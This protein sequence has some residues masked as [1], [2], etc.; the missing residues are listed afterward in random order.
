MGYC[1]RHL[2]ILLIIIG[3]ISANLIFGQNE[4]LDY[5]AVKKAI[6]G[7]WTQ[8]DTVSG[9]KVKYR[10]TTKKIT[11]YLY[12]QDNTILKRTFNYTLNRE[13]NDELNKS[14]IIMILPAKAG[15]LA[16]HDC[17]FCAEKTLDHLAFFNWMDI[18]IK[19]NKLSSFTE[20][21]NKD[22][23]TLIKE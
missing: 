15:K 2:K 10:I 19:N 4:E 11:C 3:I 16:S 5:E 22:R 9:I 12:C 23:F 20:F 21:N 6:I 8:V 18:V 17:N 14:I 1:I 13:F 7:N